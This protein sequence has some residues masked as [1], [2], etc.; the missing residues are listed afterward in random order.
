MLW[1]SLAK[2][3][4]HLLEEYVTTLFS[5]IGLIGNIYLEGL[6]SL[7]AAGGVVLQVL[8]VT[9]LVICWLLSAKLWF[10]IFEYPRALYQCQ[11]SADQRT[12]Y[13]KYFD[14]QQSL[15][16]SMGL[17]R[18]SI[19]VCPLLGLVGTVVGMIEIF[20]VISL[21][22]VSNARIMAAGVSRAILPTMAS[23]VIAIS[24]MFVFAYLQRWSAKQQMLLKSLSVS[25]RPKNHA[26]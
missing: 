7:F 22:G 8:F 9:A 23:M 11:R 13:I 14:L 5:R 1:K 24:A 17:I 3:G 25:W 20:D 10:R 15:R 21:S 18:T 2:E 4:Q 16:Q 12:F 19:N 6:Q 26:I